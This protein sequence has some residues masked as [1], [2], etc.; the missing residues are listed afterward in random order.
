MIAY[1]G[2]RVGSEVG[3]TPTAVALGKVV[4]WVY[5]LV[6]GPAEAARASA[7]RRRHSPGRG[8]PASPRVAGTSVAAAT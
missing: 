6:P 7:M 2:T 3:N 4:V 8:A 1:T 5:W